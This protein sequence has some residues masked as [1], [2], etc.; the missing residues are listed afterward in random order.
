MGI[1]VPRQA[2]LRG[3]VLGM[4]QRRL[5]EYAWFDVNSRGTTHTVG[6]KKPNARGLYDMHGNVW[7]WCGDW[8][9]DDYYQNSSPSDPTGPATGSHRVDR[10]GGWS[11][12]ARYCRSADRDWHLPG[13]ARIRLG[14]SR[15][16]G[17][18]GQVNFLPKGVRS[19]CSSTGQ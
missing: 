4:T 10:G 2:A 18:S 11:G 1:R 13:E 15:L 8:F 16:S 5:G 3:I 14:L 7:E 17:P 19:C 9:A 12:D 6:Q